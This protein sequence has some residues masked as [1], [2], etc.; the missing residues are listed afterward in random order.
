MSLLSSHKDRRK[1]EEAQMANAML[2]AANA[3]ILQGCGLKPQLGLDKRDEL[4]NKV[5]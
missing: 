5:K 1:L 3:D 2:K 4:G